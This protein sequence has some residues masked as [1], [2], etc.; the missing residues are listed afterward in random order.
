MT[1]FAA[2]IMRNCV[3][4]IVTCDTVSYYDLG[5]EMCFVSGRIGD[6][7]RLGRSI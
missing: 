3:W 7:L 2:G 5:H 1:R 6:T 4:A